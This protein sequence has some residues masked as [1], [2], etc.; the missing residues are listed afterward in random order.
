MGLK[1]SHLSD[2]ERW[3]IDTKL[4]ERQSLAAIGRT[5]GR[6][7]STICRERKRGYWQPFNAYLADFGRRYYALRRAKAGL[8][9][10]KLDQHMR[11]PAWKTVLFGLTQ[12]WSPQQLCDRLKDGL[13]PASV[14]PPGLHSLSHQTIYRSIFDM[15]PSQQRATLVKLLRRSQ[16]GRRRSRKPRSERFTGISNITPISERPLAADLRLEPG[17]WEG[18]LIRGAN[19]RSAV[20]TLVDRFTRMTLLVK[21]RSAHSTEVLRAFHQRL[22]KLPAHMRKT[23]TYDRG[24]EMACHEAF[25]A[26][27]GMPVYFCEPY[28]PWQRGTNEN[29]N[30]LIRQYLPK[31][32]DLT[33]ATNE[34]LRF[35]E[36]RLNNRP[37]RVL[38]RKTPNESYDDAVRRFAPESSA[39]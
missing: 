24:T 34:R 23:L 2:A 5:L 38:D 28:S 31:G 26:K 11:K 13:L 36:R 37:R 39:S 14:V 29:T 7:R 30:G 6:H 4:K 25:T 16:A 3:A 22:R 32:T 10:R 20:G 18:D 8:A 9:R 27:S 35:I 33:L 21:L 19:G 1:Y 17:H 12:D 15:P